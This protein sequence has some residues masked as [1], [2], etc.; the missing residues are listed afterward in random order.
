MIRELRVDPSKC[1]HCRQCL[2]VC[3]TN[4]IG[5]DE[6]KGQPYAQFPL[7][8]QLCCICE[9]AC[10]GKAITVIP[11]WSLKYYPDYLSKGGMARVKGKHNG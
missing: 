9:D 1:T 10:P 3:Y 8:C 6:A 5:W 7:D 4:V 11:D 2:D